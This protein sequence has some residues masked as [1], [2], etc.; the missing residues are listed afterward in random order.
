MM[1]YIFLF[2]AL[3][4]TLPLFSQNSNQVDPQEY[5]QLI[6]KMKKDL[7]KLAEQNKNLE[8]KNEK[9]KKNINSLK[10]GEKSFDEVNA[11]IAREEDR[12]EEAFETA[13]DILMELSEREAEIESLIEEKKAV[14]EKAKRD[15]RE[16]SSKLSKEEQKNQLN[17]QLL[18]EAKL[19]DAERQK[20]L[21]GLGA[22]S[23]F[24]L[25]LATIFYMRFQ[26]SKRQKNALEK[27]N[28]EIDQERKR[29]DELLLN[30]LPAPIA[31]ELKVS[32]KASAQKY[33]NVTVLFTDF[34][35]FTKISERLTPEQLVRELD[36]CF[37]GF[38]FIIS[39]YGIE[40]I[41]T[42]G[43]AY[44]AAT[45]LSSK[46]TMPINII[47]AA[48][49]MQE[50]LEDYK[51]ERMV[52][53]LPFFE[54]RIGIHTGPVVAGVVGVKKFAYDIWGDTVNIAARMEANAEVGRVNISEETYRQVKYNFDCEYRGK[55]EA[56]NKGYIDMYHVK[57]P[58]ANVVGSV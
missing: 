39:Q 36:Y 51:K 35:D 43:D 49:E 4:F 50:F 28:Q 45:G 48:L 19:K 10:S 56:K 58:V 42:I 53:G 29:S 47:K 14:Q 44:M 8:T 3:V 31:N 6:R 15:T 7:D 22:A 23:L 11:E 37:R 25:L 5:I 20:F 55:I 32:G 16:L 54:A 17:Q 27:I 46:R 34:K 2:V 13:E 33:Q 30:I 52:K 40:K 57:Q 26:S 1:K 41:K 18:T 12:E 38:D 24:I 9:L 21:Y